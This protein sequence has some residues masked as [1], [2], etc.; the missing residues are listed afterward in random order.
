MHAQR[1][2]RLVMEAATHFG[3]E[4]ELQMTASLPHSTMAY[5]T[6][7]ILGIWE[8]LS[9]LQFEYES[10]LNMNMKPFEKSP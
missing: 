9:Y 2:T 4:E 10:N 8:G 7:V 5:C 1:D 6:A 3:A